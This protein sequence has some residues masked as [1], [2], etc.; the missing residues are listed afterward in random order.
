[1]SVLLLVVLVLC[2]REAVV[3]AV[4]KRSKME[5]DFERREDNVDFF[6]V[7]VH[8]LIVFFSSSFFSS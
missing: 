4:F 2:K 3:S 6:L 1:M 8:F 7:V 5:G